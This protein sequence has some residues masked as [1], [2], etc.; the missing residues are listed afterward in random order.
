MSLHNIHLVTEG[1]AETSEK[2]TRSMSLHNIQ[3]VT[4]GAAE[5]FPRCSAASGQCLHSP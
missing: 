3:L 5:T 2:W 4:E 1:V